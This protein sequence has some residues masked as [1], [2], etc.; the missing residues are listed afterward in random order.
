MR[1]I[2]PPQPTPFSRPPET[3]PVVYPDEITIDNLLKRGLQDLYGLMRAIRID[4]NTGAPSRETVQNL[5]DAMS[6]LHDLKKK[7][8]AVLDEMTDEELEIASK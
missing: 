8:E 1:R 3:E 4:I 2:P 6:M 7:E 5:K